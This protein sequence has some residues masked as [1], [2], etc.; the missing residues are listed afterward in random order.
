[1]QPFLFKLPVRFFSLLAAAVPYRRQ[2]CRHG[3]RNEVQGSRWAGIC[4]ACVKQATSAVGKRIA[5]RSARL[6]VLKARL[7]TRLKWGKKCS[8]HGCRNDAASP[9]ARFCVACFKQNGAETIE[10]KCSTHGCRHDAASHRAFFCTPCFKKNAA[11]VGR[12]R[13]NPLCLEEMQHS[14]LQE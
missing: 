7:Q 2:C 3:C 8:R 13:G 10:K 9:G 6:V 4:L 1:M 12:L 11:V 14:C 5:Q